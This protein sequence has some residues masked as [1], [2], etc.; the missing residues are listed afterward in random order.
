[1]NKTPLILVFK[2]LQ[3]DFATAKH[4]ELLEKL[5]KTKPVAYLPTLVY[6][7]LFD[8]A[9]NNLLNKK[10]NPFAFHLTYKYL[11]GKFDREVCTLSNALR[12]LKEAK[13]IGMN[14]IMVPNDEPN[15]R[16]KS[17]PVSSITLK[18]SASMQKS[19]QAKVE[20]S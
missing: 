20:Q 15:S 10:E 9:Y 19:I 11:L 12:S 13:L 14:R 6:F 4:G 5:F 3:I 1:M 16:F 17:K 8:I 2:N 7:E 18:L